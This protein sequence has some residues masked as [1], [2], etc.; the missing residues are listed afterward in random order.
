M[1]RNPLIVPF[2][3]FSIIISLYLLYSPHYAA[4]TSDPALCYKPAVH[5][6]LLKTIPQKRHRVAV[7]SM[8]SYHFDVYMSFA[9]SLARAMNSS[10][11]GG[12]IEVYAETPFKYHFQTIIEDLHMYPHGYRDPQDLLPAIRNQMGDGGIDTVVLGTCEADL[13]GDWT[14]DLISIWDERDDAHKFQLICIVHNV[15]DTAWQPAIQEWSRRNAIRLVTISEH[16][17]YSFREKFSELADSPD[18]VVRSAG[19]ERIPTDVHPPVLPLPNLPEHS[20]NR[21]LSKAVI[22]GSFDTV[23]RDYNNIFSDLVASLREDPAAWGYLPLGDQPSYVPN[24]NHPSA[25]FQLY[26]IGS[27][28]LSIPDELKNV[29]VVKTGMSYP[30]FYELMSQMDICVPAFAEFG[31]YRIQASSTFAMAVQCNVPILVTQ[32][33]RR[34]YAYVDDDRAVVTRPAAMREVAALKALRT[35]DPSPF[36]ETS[37][38]NMQVDKKL[39]S[40][41]VIRDGVRDMISRGWAR[42]GNDMENFKSDLWE[43]NDILA[44]RILRDL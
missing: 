23:R 20:Y 2:I 10:S 29:V 19:Y 28:W 16:V 27:G 39:G 31:Y 38:P 14:K 17:A 13:H 9:W 22:Q 42:K 36:L 4:P 33:M 41:T 25:P 6:S 35:G 44:Q 24:P 21:S 30:E 26:T 5:P 12:S 1:S 15:A 40:N 18:A 8:F 32:R 37:M 11:T 34:S 3:L 7:A 43:R